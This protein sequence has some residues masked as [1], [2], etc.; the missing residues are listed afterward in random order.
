MNKYKRVLLV[1]GDIIAYRSSSVAETPVNWGD[2][3]WTLHA[4]EQDV[5]THLDDYHHQLM[6][7]LGAD[8]AIYC[9]TDSDANWR[10]DILPSYKG[11]RKDVRKPL[12]LPW[13][14]DYLMLNYDTF[15]RPNL[16]G[17][18]VMGILATHPNLI[19]ADE[20][21]IV[22]IDKDMKTI[23]GWVFNEA[24]DEE[25]RWITPEEAEWWHMYQTLTGD[26]TDGYSGCPGIGPKSAEKILENPRRLE[27][28][29]RG[30]STV[31]KDVGPA[32]S[33]WEAVV[34]QFRKAGLDEE[35]AL[36]QARVARILHYS[37][38]SFKKKAPI[39]W[40]P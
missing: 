12:M 6:E 7:T 19:A 22:S 27:E 3:L 23:P 29:P 20:K 14:R 4:Y 39:L 8:H 10:K 35:D 32:E 11:N 5:Q 30:A 26:T 38:Y 40:T 9:L 24:K 17:D 28:V 1:D 36:V 13:A 25:P 16:E 37:D 15:L 21:I 34:C 2:G 33:L 31:W 18:D